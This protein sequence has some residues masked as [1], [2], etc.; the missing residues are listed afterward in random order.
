MGSPTD[1]TTD[2]ARKHRQRRRTPDAVHKG[3]ANNAC[4]H[5]RADLTQSCRKAKARFHRRITADLHALTVSQS[6]MAAQEACQVTR[7]GEQ[8]HSERAQTLCLS[9]FHF[10]DREWLCRQHQRRSE[11]R[12]LD[13]KHCCYLLCSCNLQGRLLTNADGG[14]WEGTVLVDLES[15][16]EH[17]THNEAHSRGVESRQHPAVPD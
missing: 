3:I 12:C 13:H 10:Q 16:G 7:A 9:A 11:C 6:T 17:G 15:Q 14:C 2:A 1:D 4:K 8:Q 5:A